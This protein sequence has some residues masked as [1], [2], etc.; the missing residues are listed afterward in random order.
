[1]SPDD[2]RRISINKI[3]AAHRARYG[4]CFVDI[5]S[6]VTSD[7]WWKYTMFTPTALDLALQNTGNLPKKGSQNSSHLNRV[8]SGAVVNYVRDRILS[9]GWFN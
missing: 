8:G 4:E 9:L 6:L 3:N 2:P 5:H 1:M 7:D